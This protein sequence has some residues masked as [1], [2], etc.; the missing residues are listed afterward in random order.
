MQYIIDKPTRH[1]QKWE[2]GEKAR[3]N[4]NYGKQKLIRTQICKFFKQL[5][6]VRVRGVFHKYRIVENNA[7][8]TSATVN[9]QI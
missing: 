5:T 9:R 6:R 3:I 1:Y 4:E 8:F 2:N 7:I